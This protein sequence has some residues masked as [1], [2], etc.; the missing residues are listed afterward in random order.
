VDFVII[1]KPTVRILD[2]PLFPHPPRNYMASLVANDIATINPK[3]ALDAGAGELRMF[4]LFPPGSYTGV[5]LS[6][7][8]F[9]MGIR[10]HKLT[11]EDLAQ[12]KIIVA[13]LNKDFAFLGSFDLVVCTGTAHSFS[14]PAHTLKRLAQR[15]VPRGNMLFQTPAVFFENIKDVGIGAMFDRV[16][17]VPYDSLGIPPPP[18]CFQHLEADELR[19]NPDGFYAITPKIRQALR[20]LCID[21]MNANTGLSTSKSLYFRCIGRNGNE[22]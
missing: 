22:V 6:R 5:G 19:R 3:R 15:L 7:E 13:D 12:S 17:V 10:R 1:A 4:S 21:E 14:E 2:P 16:E 11:A 20:K 8:E 18:A 9:E